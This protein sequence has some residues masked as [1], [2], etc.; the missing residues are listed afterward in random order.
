MS[1]DVYSN[2]KGPAHLSGAFVSNGGENLVLLLILKQPPEC[3]RLSL[4]ENL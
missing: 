4:R 2:D 1:S 3:R